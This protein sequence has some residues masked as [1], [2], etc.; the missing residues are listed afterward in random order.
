[1][2]AAI[3]QNIYEMHVAAVIKVSNQIK[4]VPDWKALKG[5]N[6]HLFSHREKHTQLE[7][8]EM[9]QSEG[10][11]CSR[12]NVKYWKLFILWNNGHYFQ[13]WQ[14][15]EPYRCTTLIFC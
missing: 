2:D 1:M 5:W 14:L 11:C 13:L 9:R 6:K 10:R 7:T 15:R 4:A 8:E 3:V 12:K